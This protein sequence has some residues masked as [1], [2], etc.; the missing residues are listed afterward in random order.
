MQN[1][2]LHESSLGC[3]DF[4]KINSDKFQ[5]KTK[6][7]ILPVEETWTVEVIDEKQINW[8]VEI[9]SKEQI[10]ILERKVAL[11]FSEQYRKW[12]DAW[13]E[14][15]FPRIDDCTEVELR[16]PLSN[17]VGL[18][19]R[20]KLKGQLPT[21]LLELYKDNGDFYPS[22]KNA[23]LP[24]GARM[25]EV[26]SRDLN[27]NAK[28]VTGKFTVFSGRIKIVEEDFNKRKSQSKK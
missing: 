19:G 10:E 22:I 1:R 7:G 2:Q 25:L 18:R 28:I 12:I 8:N 26:G 9:Y 6:Y 24:L 20:K 14:G 4:E 23:V 15:Y 13:G 5:I 11:I 21:I 17:F 3:W 27:G 16:N